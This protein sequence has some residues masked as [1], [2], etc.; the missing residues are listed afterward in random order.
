MNLVLSLCSGSRLEQQREPSLG[1]KSSSIAPAATSSRALALHIKQD[2]FARFFL[3]IL[4]L[5]LRKADEVLIEEG[6]FGIG[7]DV[8]GHVSIWFAERGSHLAP[9]PGDC[10]SASTVPSCSG[11]ETQ[12]QSLMKWMLMN[13]AA[14]GLKVPQCH[15]LLKGFR[16]SPP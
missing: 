10:L 7:A 9:S 14:W 12:L 2:H 3:C 1:L 4:Y 16:K 15:V 5:L 6:C 13:S 11:G 8:P